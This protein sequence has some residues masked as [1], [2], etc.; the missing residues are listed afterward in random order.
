MKKLIK[1]ICFTLVTVLCVGGGGCGNQKPI[2]YT[3]TYNLDGGQNHADNPGS[4]TEQDQIVLKVPSKTGFVFVEWRKDGVKI[5]QIERGSKGNLTLTAVWEEDISS[6]PP[7][8][9]PEETGRQIQMVGQTFKGNDVVYPDSLWSAPEWN[10]EPTLDF[11]MEDTEGVKGIFYTSIPYEGKPTRVAAYIGFPEN[12]SSTNKVPAMVLVHGG[13]GTAIP[14]WVKYWND[15]GYAAISMDTEGAEPI[16]GISNYETSTYHVE[17]NRYANDQ[18]YSS[19]PANSGYSDYQKSVE[20]QWMYHATSSVIVATSLIASFECVDIQKIGMTGI[21][22]GSVITSI[23]ISYDDR[24]TF[25]MPVYGGI[26]IGQSYSDMKNNHPNQLSKDRWDNLEGLKQSNCKTF[27]VTADN[28][29]HFSLDIAS[30][31]AGATNGSVTYINGFTHG[32]AEGAYQEDLHLFANLMTGK[33][34]D[35]VTVT[36]QPTKVDPVIKVEK[37]G[38][39]KIESVWIYY[40][41]DTDLGTSAKWYTKFVSYDDLT[42]YSLTLPECSTAY[43]RVRY[44][45]DHT[46]CSYLF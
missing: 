38:N 20:E 41:S 2:V 5:E 23:V 21:S 42:E 12:A 39:A 45:G 34:A 44:N 26:S 22:W 11:D 1:L 28:D 6:V 10:Y 9:P 18:T 30:R 7:I 16:D 4:Y 15:L 19:G 17:E 46:V 3:I 13:L 32:Q 43:V 35:F 24:I 25:A 31:C 37:H 40:T 29:F 33:T 27:Y 8:E 14:Q 36:K